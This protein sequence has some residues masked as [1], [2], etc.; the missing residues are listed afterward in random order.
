MACGSNRI[1]VIIPCHRVVASDGK[2]H[3][4]GGGLETKR[5][6]LALEGVGAGQRRWHSPA[7]EMGRE[8]RCFVRHGDQRSEGKALL[9]TNELIFRGDFRLVIP[10]R[11]I[12]ALEAVDGE[13]RVR[14]PEGDA[15]FELG[16]EASKWATAIRNPRGLLD[17]L[18]VK[19]G[20][21]VS[22]LGVADTDFLDQ[23]WERTDRLSEQPADIIFYEADDVDDLVRLPELARRIDRKGAIWVVSPKGKGAKVR[24][25]DVMAAARD[26]GLV[27]TKVVSFSNTHTA[28][29]LVIPV[30]QR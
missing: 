2:L 30:A 12:E 4:Y 28:L 16:S 27:D 17:K 29:K 13:L 26:A 15:V 7:S 3:G 25:V 24:D 23:L 14:S 8:A 22:V 18:G 20:A 1:A 6:L 11:Q 10:L 9:E 21:R 19:A 5:W